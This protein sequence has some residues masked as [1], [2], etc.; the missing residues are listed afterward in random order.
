MSHFGE[1]VFTC[2]HND[3]L[4]LTVVKSK[5]PFSPKDESPKTIKVEIML[6]ELLQFLF[7]V[8]S[9]MIWHLLTLQVN[10]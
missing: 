1:N 6:Q 5:G 3:I 9:G 7:Q 8:V 10:Q 4:I 2:L